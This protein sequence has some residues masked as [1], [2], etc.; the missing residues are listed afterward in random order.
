MELSTS[1]PD[2]N[3]FLSKDKNPEEVL[4][5]LYQSLGRN[6]LISFHKFRSKLIVQI[7]PS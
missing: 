7:E 2:V 3:Y 1:L 5:E 4:H 6:G